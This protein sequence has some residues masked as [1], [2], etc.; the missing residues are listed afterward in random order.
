MARA[1]TLKCGKCGRTFS[2]PAHLAR[3]LS[4]SHGRKPKGVRRARGRRPGMSSGMGRRGRPPAIATRLGLSRLGND[5]LVQL[6]GATRSL[7]QQRLQ[8]LQ[9][10]IG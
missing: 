7:L 8:V 3:H 4:A 9:E 1:K 5:E 2:M 6:L 10:V